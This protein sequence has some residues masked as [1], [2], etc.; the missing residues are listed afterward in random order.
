M[1]TVNYN[2]L[3]SEILPYC[4]SA[5][6]PEIVNVIRRIVRDFLKRTNYLT[7]T[8]DPKLDITKDEAQYEIT[9]PSGLEIV[10]VL[11]VFSGDEQLTHKSADQFDREH[12]N[13]DSVGA[14]YYGTS[15]HEAF[16]RGIRDPWRLDTGPKAI[17][18][19][20]VRPRCI[21]IV[22]IPETAKTAD[23][24]IT[25]SVRPNRTSVDVED[26][27]IDNWYETIVAGVI[28]EMM[29]MPKKKWSD[30]KNGAARL[31][32]YDDATEELINERAAGFVDNSHGIGRTR[33][34]P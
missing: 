1:A 20:Q 33:A 14:I 24:Q 9:Q 18:W 7:I 13:P 29:L 12:G 27:V 34:Y 10:R 32:Q 11:Q 21:Q 22:P 26:W 3:L 16:R 2:D 19:F 15:H 31:S 5:S 25:V 6:E 17:Y 8:S 30:V 28:G 4:P 23:L